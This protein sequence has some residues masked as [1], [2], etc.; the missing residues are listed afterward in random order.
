MAEA[1]AKP[2]ELARSAKE[3]LAELTGR[4]PEGV[5]GIER[6]DDDGW[7]VTLEL[8]ELERV[9]NS[10]DLLGCYLVSLDDSGE[11]VEY[12]RLRRY[13]RGQADEDGR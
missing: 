9:P 5:L 12:R 4:K 13:S 7:H 11:L 3:Q 1:K 2:A 10:T 8:L 6:N